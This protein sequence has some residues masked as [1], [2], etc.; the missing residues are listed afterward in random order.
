MN[1]SDAKNAAINGK[2]K[3]TKEV[4]KENYSLPYVLIAAENA[5]FPLNRVKS[6]PFIAENALSDTVSKTMIFYE[7]IS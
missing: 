4:S 3:E 5:R 1:L 2:H 7:Q 6:G